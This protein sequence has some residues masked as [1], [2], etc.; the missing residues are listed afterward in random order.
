MYDYTKQTLDLTVLSKKS[1][2][3]TLPFEKY[4]NSIELFKLVNFTKLLVNLTDFFNLVGFIHLICCARC[5][6]RV[7]R[8]APVCSLD[9]WGGMVLQSAEKEGSPSIVPGHTVLFHRQ[10]LPWS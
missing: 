7:C 9:R 1:C 6:R 4:M 8:Q 3:Y 10:L 2:K 5:H